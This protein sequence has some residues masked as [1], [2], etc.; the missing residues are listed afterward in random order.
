MK[1]LLLPQTEVWTDA[2]VVPINAPH[3]YEAELL[4]NYMLEPKVNV[5][6]ALEFLYPPIIDSQ[7]I[8][9]DSLEQIKLMPDFV[10]DNYDNLAS[11]T[12]D[13]TTT[14]NKHGLR[15]GHQSWPE[16]KSF[17]MWATE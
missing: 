16:R 6:L 7:Y 9:S 1:T 5:A 4:L 14:T 13:T 2:F 10:G 3:R 8:P 17:T 12:P 11:L 15:S